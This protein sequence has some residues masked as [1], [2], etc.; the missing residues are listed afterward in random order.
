MSSYFFKIHMLTGAMKVVTG[1]FTNVSEW[2]E[3]TNRVQGV[4]TYVYK[5]L[6]LVFITTH[7]PI[8]QE[9]SQRS[10]VGYFKNTVL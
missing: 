3:Y 2:H 8:E 7:V 9:F 6:N 5:K 10:H 4:V 1:A